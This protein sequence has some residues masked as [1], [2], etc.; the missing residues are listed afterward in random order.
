MSCILCDSAVLSA[1]ACVVPRA[2][3]RIFSSGELGGLT[4]TPRA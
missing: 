1:H 3:E 4:C 2:L